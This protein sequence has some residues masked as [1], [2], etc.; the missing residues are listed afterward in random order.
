MAALHSH[1]KQSTG[2]AELTVT[3][4]SLQVW[5]ALQSVSLIQRND[6]LSTVTLIN[7]LL[8]STEQ[9]QSSSWI[10]C[11]YCACRVYLCCHNPLNSDMDYRIFNVRTDVNACN[12]TW[13]GGGVWTP[14]E[15]LHWKLTP[16]RKSIAA[17]ENWTYVSGVMVWYS[18]NR[19]TSHPQSTVVA[20]TI[21]AS[22]SLQVWQT[23]YSL[24]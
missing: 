18:T 24:T 1:F 9:P 23:T 21:V 17:L 14:K 11:R 8:L 15:S 19:V 5:Q 20:D 2:V 13:G 6:R 10:F 12:C 16:G 22:I 4:I 3:S 7:L